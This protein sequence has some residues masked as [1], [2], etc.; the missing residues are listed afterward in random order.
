MVTIIAKETYKKTNVNI[1]GKW[2]QLSYAG[3][4]RVPT[5]EEPY[6]S[7]WPTY[8]FSRDEQGRFL[9][10]DGNIVAFEIRSPDQGIDFE[11]KQLSIVKETLDNLTDFQKKVATYWG[12]G[13]ATKQFTPIIDILITTY[14]ISAPRAARILAAIQGALN[15]AFV[16]AWHFKFRWQIPRPNQLDQTLKT[17]LCTPRHPSYPAGH[18]TIAGCAETVLSYFFEADKERLNELAKQCAI[19]RLYGGVHY[20]I[21]LREGLRLGRQIG[22]IVVEQL[23]NQYDINL[24]Q[25]DYPILVSKHPKLP[26]PPYKQVIPD[27]GSM[28]CTSL[29]IDDD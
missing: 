18:A 1:P 11:G 7:S 6:A 17:F 5:K 8:F 4:K 12:T 28:K 2:E 19:S 3:E 13:P 25:I 9:D 20:P 23:K 22:R 10:P 14:N 24:S 15:D 27:F 29:T 26:P 21:D 16:I